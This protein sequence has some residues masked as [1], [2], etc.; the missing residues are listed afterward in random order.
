MMTK[1]FLRSAYMAKRMLLDKDKQQQQVANMVMQFANIPLPQL[2]FAMSYFA[3][4]AKSEIAAAPFETAIQ[5]SYPYCCFCYPKINAANR[6]MEAIEFTK[7][8][9]LSINKWGIAEP[10]DGK[11]IAPQL[12]DLILVPLLCFDKQGYRVGYGKGFY[13]R[14]IPRCRADTITIGLSFF[15]PVDKIED[16]D[17]Y[18]VPLTFCVTPERLYHF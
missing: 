13:D 10:E 7:G 16:I 1:H 6:S 2:K 9:Q 4:T 11:I 12:I 17:K 5:Y 15:E 18:D 14:F 8:H 3:L